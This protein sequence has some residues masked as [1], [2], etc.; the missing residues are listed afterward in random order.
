MKKINLQL[1]VVFFLGACAISLNS[2]HGSL[3][4]SSSHDHAHRIG[5]GS[6]MDEDDEDDDDD[7]DDDD[8]AYYDIMNRDEV[9]NSNIYAIPYDD[10]E[11]EDEEEI[12]RLTKD[13]GKEEF[14]LPKPK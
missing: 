12:D 2:V 3:H 14:H 8:D 9:D 6:V 10:S 4:N 1:F 7:D 5:S 13:S 11:V